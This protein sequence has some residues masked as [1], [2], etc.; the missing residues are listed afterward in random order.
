MA[1]E[2]KKD[3]TPVTLVT[4]DIIT[5]YRKDEVFTVPKYVA[6]LL[7][8]DNRVDEDGKVQPVKVRLYDP[9]KDADLLAEQRGKTEDAVK[10]EVTQPAKA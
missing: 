8:D 3:V 1:K 2:K 4:T 9:A 5:P 6:D 10:P 7:L